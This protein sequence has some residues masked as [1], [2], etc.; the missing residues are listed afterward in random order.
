MIRCSPMTLETEK[1]KKKK[2][3]KKKVFSLRVDT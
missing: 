1:K 2:K 3:K